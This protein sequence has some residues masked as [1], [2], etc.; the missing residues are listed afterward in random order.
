[1]NS[2]S[3][4]DWWNASSPCHDASSVSASAVTTGVTCS[5]PNSSLSG[6]IQLAG[7]TG[8][9]TRRR[10]NTGVERSSKVTLPLNSS[11][12]S[13]PSPAVALVAVSISTR[14]PAFRTRWPV[15]LTDW[16]ATSACDSP[17]IQPS[18]SPATVSRVCGAAARARIR[19]LEICRTTVPCL[20]TARNPEPTSPLAASNPR[21]H[22]PGMMPRKCVRIPAGTPFSSGIV[23][24]RTAPDNT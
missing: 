12:Q 8:K 13:T 19:A 4:S 9:S 7:V 5:A 15:R 3:R 6:W 20:A 10:E 24:I 1:M 18:S 16:S 14:S 22:W 17:P 11:I 21:K 23:K 2:D